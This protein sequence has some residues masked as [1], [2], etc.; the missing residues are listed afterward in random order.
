MED[1]FRLREA[2]VVGDEVVCL[3]EDGHESYFPGPQLR[4]ACTCASCKGEAHLFGR[5]TLPTLRPL[6]PEAFVPVAVRR[7]GHYGLQVVWGDGHDFGI[8]HLESLRRAC[9]CGECTAQGGGS[10]APMA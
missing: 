2:M 6:P 7:V 8:Y 4:R 9:P 10:Y 3:W 5:R 1:R